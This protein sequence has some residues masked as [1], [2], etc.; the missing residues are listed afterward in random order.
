MQEWRVDEHAR[1]NLTKMSIF[2]RRFCGDRRFDDF[3]LGRGSV[4]ILEGKE[5]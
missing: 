2:A 5:K 4:W 3:F 1:E